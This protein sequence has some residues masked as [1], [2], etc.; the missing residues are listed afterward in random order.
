MTL[1]FGAAGCLVAAQ[2][3]GIYAL[4]TRK[5]DLIF[6]FFMVVLVISALLLGYLGARQQLG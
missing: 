6:R 5:A 4:R 1:L 3:L 2:V